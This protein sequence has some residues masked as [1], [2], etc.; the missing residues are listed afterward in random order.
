MS[1]YLWLVLI[2]PMERLSILLDQTVAMGHNLL[3]QPFFKDLH[4]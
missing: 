3:Q 2:K 1:Q 4:I